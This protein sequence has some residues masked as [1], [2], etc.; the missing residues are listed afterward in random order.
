MVSKRMYHSPWCEWVVTC[1]RTRSTP[2]RYWVFKLP[3]ICIVED[4]ASV[5]T[6]TARFLRSIGYEVRT[7]DSAEAYLTADVSGCR[8][9]VCDVR[10]PGM[11]GIDLYEKLRAETRAVPT[12]FITAHAQD[13]VEKRG[14]PK[15]RILGKPFDGSDLARCLEDLQTAE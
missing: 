1:A 3:T 7:F 14:W 5:R 11:S 13:V 6:A 4:D 15:T 9:L 10:M 12:V 2:E 8:C